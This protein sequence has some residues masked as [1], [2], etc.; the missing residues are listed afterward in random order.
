MD[1]RSK[2]FLH[3]AGNISCSFWALG[4]HW[5]SLLAGVRNLSVEPA[6]PQPLNAFTLCCPSCSARHTPLYEQRMERVCARGRK[7]LSPHLCTCRLFFIKERD[8][9]KMEEGD[10]GI[11]EGMSRGKRRG[12]KEY[13]GGAIFRLAASWPA[14]THP[15]PPSSPHYWPCLWPRAFLRKISA[16]RHTHT[17]TLWNMYSSQFVH[18]FKCLAFSKIQVRKHSLTHTHTQSHGIY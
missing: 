1:L 18:C 17:H 11:A 6:L 9:E 7:H 2:S 14:P 10:E 3:H 8:D 15:S 12:Q 16:L 13:G 5:N 4:S